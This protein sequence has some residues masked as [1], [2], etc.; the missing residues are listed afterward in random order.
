MKWFSQIII[1]NCEVFSIISQ[2]IVW[3]CEFFFPPKAYEIPLL[4][5]ALN[6]SPPLF[7]WMS[8]TNLRRK[9]RYQKQLPSMGFQF[10]SILASIHFLVPLWRL[11]L[12]IL[13]TEFY[14]LDNSHAKKKD[15][16]RTVWFHRATEVAVNCSKRNHEHPSTQ[17]ILN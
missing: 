16:A 15:M 5:H 14:K 8:P 11:K 13:Q 6:Y 4:R 1:W 17:P 2:M 7:G 3:N 10:A 9:I 12:T